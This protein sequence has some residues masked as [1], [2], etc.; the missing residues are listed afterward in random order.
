MCG[1]V[2]P[3]STARLPQRP[4]PV[5]VG[6]GVLHDQRLDPLGVGQRQPEP[7]RSAVILQKQDVPCETEPGGEAVDD[8]GEVIERV[9]EDCRVWRIAVPKSGIVRRDQ[10]EGIRQPD[11]ERLSHAR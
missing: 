4:E 6:D 1:A 7:D 2:S 11:Q 10:V 5:L 3:E 8:L 9:V